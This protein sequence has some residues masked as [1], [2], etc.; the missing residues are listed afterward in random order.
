[1]DTLAYISKEFSISNPKAQQMIN[2]FGEEKVL[3]L[4]YNHQ[5]TFIPPPIKSY[6]QRVK[7]LR[8]IYGKKLENLH[9]EKSTHNR[10]IARRQTIVREIEKEIDEIHK[11]WKL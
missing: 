11:L 6:E 3:Q 5:R 8:K 2:I 4:A 1:M 9:T 7:E 10:E